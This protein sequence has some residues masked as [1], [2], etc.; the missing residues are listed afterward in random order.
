M[1][2]KL[3]MQRQLLR[4]DLSNQTKATKVRTEFKLIHVHLISSLCQE[5]SRT[6]N[7]PSDQGKW[8]W[9]CRKHLNLCLS[10]FAAKNYDLSHKSQAKISQPSFVMKFDVINVRTSEQQAFPNSLK[11]RPNLNL[12]K[13]LGASMNFLKRITN[14]L[15]FSQAW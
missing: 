14:I 4:M 1:N 3:G 10:L 12:A 2:F 5:S 7:I 11:S 15:I 9:T 13:P 6:P 8:K